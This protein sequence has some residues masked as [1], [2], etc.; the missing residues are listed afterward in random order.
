MIRTYFQMLL[1]D[2]SSGVPA[3]GLRP[4]GVKPPEK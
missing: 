3:D 1:D 2:S 4:Q